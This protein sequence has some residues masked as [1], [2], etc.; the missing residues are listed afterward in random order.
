MIILF[1]QPMLLK[2][3]TYITSHN[4]EQLLIDLFIDSN[5]RFLSQAISISL[6]RS[7]WNCWK[8]RTAACFLNCKCHI[9]FPSPS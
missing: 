6:M 2:G 3:I 7:H 9:E 8:A 1:R 5:V 4:R